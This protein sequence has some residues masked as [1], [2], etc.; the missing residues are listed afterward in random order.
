MSSEKIFKS[1]WSEKK[2][3]ACIQRSP[4]TVAVHDKETWLSLFSSDGLVNDPVGSKPHQGRD[5]IDRFYETFIAPNA[6]RFDV[7]QDA[8]C[9]D[10]VVRDLIIETRMSTG[11]RVDVPTHIRYELVEEEGELKVNRL[12]AHWELAP[13]VLQTLKSGLKGLVTYTKLSAH[14]I[15]CQ[16]IGGV[17]GFMRGFLGVGKRGK[18][19]AENLF[20]ALMQAD[21]VRARAM[22]ASDADVQCGSKNGCALAQLIEVIKGMRWTKVI[23]AGRS[24]TATIRIGDRH[25]LIL[26]VFDRR[27]RVEQLRVYLQG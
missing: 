13:M 19:R 1:E 10:T 25:G 26:L 12:Y 5:E 3:L 6:I 8:V 2:M 15:A 23:A 9:G 4:D 18:R 14:M 27:Y 21:A 22:L 24:V 17:L 11:L 20:T 16:G 7:K